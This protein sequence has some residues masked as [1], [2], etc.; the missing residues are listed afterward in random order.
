MWVKNA[1]SEVRNFRALVL[2][3]LGALSSAYCQE[4]KNPFSMMPKVQYA[5]FKE[6]LPYNRRNR[7]KICGSYSRRD[8]NIVNI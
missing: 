4:A 5:E 7:R 3:A 1:G 2:R 6:A 8:L